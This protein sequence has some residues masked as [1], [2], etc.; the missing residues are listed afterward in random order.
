MDHEFMFD[1]YSRRTVYSASHCNCDD[2][3][4]TV[5]MGNQAYPFANNNRWNVDNRIEQ[6]PLDPFVGYVYLNLQEYNVNKH[7]G[8]NIF[9][10]DH[11]EIHKS[12]K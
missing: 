7:S 12:V 8:L 2:K 9:P 5:L 3:K 10:D 6:Y 1:P 4:N 11:G